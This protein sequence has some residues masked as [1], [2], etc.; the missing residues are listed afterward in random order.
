MR[1]QGVR[2]GNCNVLVSNRNEGP[3]LTKATIKQINKNNSWP[4]KRS[5]FMCSPVSSRSTAM[6][7]AL[8]ISSSIV[9]WAACLRL[10][11]TAA[12]R[13]VAAAAAA[14]LPLPLPLPGPPLTPLPTVH[15]PLPP[16]PCPL[17]LPLSLSLPRAWPMG[18]GSLLS[19]QCVSS[20]TAPAPAAVTTP[21]SIKYPC[22]RRLRRLPVLRGDGETGIGTSQRHPRRRRTSRARRGSQDIG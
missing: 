17:R 2:G 7:S 10:L 22:C 19:G 16:A 8:R 18:P 12:T 9:A 3:F 13:T 11:V 21:A 15:C 14:P 1:F 20:P 6:N 4:M 5:D